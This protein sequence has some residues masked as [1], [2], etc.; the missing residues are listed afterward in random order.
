MR[1]S[2]EQR[3][4]RE[5]MEHS[6]GKPKPELTTLKELPPSA[7]KPEA[8]TAPAKKEESADEKAV[9][10]NNRQ[11]SRW[12]PEQKRK[13]LDYYGKNAG[14]RFVL[15]DIPDVRVSQ[16]DLGVTPD[17]RVGTAT[18]AKIMALKELQPPAPKK[19]AQDAEKKRKIAELK[20]QIEAEKGNIRFIEQSELPS[21]DKEIKR[22]ETQMKKLFGAGVPTS[23]SK[24]YEWLKFILSQRTD[25]RA[26]AWADKENFQ[27]DMN[28]MRIYRS[29]L[30]PK[31]AERKRLVSQ[32]NAAKQ[33]VVQLQKRIAA[34]K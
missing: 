26:P 32:A 31:L 8:P 18:V 17:G 30:K 5:L 10:Y 9:K 7:P 22:L 19:P 29:M 25:P 20:K 15:S 33:K 1:E 4:I 12:T 23:K 6:A 34:L 14:E 16:G 28:R 27:I 3:G 2:D 21:L 13:V 11:L 24:W